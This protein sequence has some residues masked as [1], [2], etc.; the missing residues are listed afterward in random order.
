MEFIP[1][2]FRKS[3]DI[4][5]LSDSSN[6]WIKFRRLRFAAAGDGEY[7]ALS[8]LD[9]GGLN[10]HDFVADHLVFVH[11][12]LDG[13]SFAGTDFVFDTIFI[14]CSM[15]GVNLMNTHSAGALFYGCDMTGARF[16][17]TPWTN[18]DLDNQKI[19]S[20]F[21]DCSLEK[22]VQEYLVEDGNYIGTFAEVDPYIVQRITEATNAPKVDL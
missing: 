11:C 10:L 12:N 15:Q 14:G 5:V 17:G 13:A 22:S 1:K 4:E 19:R 7:A 8:D 20:Y 3:N 2:N 18:V 9:L 21:I 16:P 6:N